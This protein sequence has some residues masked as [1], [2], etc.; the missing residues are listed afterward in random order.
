MIVNDGLRNACLLGEPSQRQGVRALFPDQPPRHI[1]KLALALLSRQA[2]ARLWW[3]GQF[4]RH[5]A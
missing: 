4:F 2:A 1:Q 5:G 3:G